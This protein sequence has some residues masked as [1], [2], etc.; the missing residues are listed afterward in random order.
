MK[1]HSNINVLILN[2]ENIEVEEEYSQLFSNFAKR[3]L[4]VG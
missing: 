2:L 1:P 4:K 3:K